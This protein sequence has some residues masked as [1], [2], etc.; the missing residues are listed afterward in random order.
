MSA[1]LLP[2]LAGG[3]RLG[4]ELAA[5]NTCSDPD[6]SWQRH[7]VCGM[8]T[9][10]VRAEY[11]D[12]VWHRRPCLDCYIILGINKPLPLKQHRSCDTDRPMEEQ[13]A[14]ALFLVPCGSAA[15]EPLTSPIIV[16]WEKKVIRIRRMEQDWPPF[17]WWHIFLQCLQQHSLIT[18][19]ANQSRWHW[20]LLYFVLFLLYCKNCLSQ[21]SIP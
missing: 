4:N 9:L 18:A 8:A 10:P 7:H 17:F 19:Y 15:G 12:S 13:T 6:S 2:R 1:V 5:A 16:N 3:T 20:Y 11:W 14:L 21:V